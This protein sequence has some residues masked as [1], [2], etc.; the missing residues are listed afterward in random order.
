MYSVLAPISSLTHYS[1]SPGNH[2]ITQSTFTDPCDPMPGGFDSGWVSIPNAGVNPPPEWNLTITDASK[3]IILSYPLL[4]VHSTFPPLSSHLVL[5]QAALTRHPLF[6]WFYTSFIFF[7]IIFSCSFVQAWSA[8][9][10][11]RYLG[12]THSPHTRT[13]LRI[14]R[15]H[16]AYVS[17]LYMPC[18]CLNVIFLF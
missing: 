8:R 3:R 6:I 7:D 4:K 10:T 16:P 2:S 11:H 18:L 1:C 12:V 13:M 5:L 15:G 14:S 17:T 9:S